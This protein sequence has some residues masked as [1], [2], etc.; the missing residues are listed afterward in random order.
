MAQTISI[1]IPRRNLNYRNISGFLFPGFSF[2]LIMKHHDDLCSK[3]A[4]VDYI[5]PNWEDKVM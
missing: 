3:K 2:R 1:L 5:L 4:E